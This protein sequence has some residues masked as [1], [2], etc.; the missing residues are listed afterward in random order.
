MRDTPR[1]RRRLGPPAAGI[2]AAV[3]VLAAAC[4]G[5]TGPRVASAG[6]ASTGRSSPGSSTSHS[7]LPFSHCMRSHGVPRYPD[8]EPQSPNFPAVVGSAHDVG[9][10]SSRLQAAE[11]AC[12]HTLPYNDS[13]LTHW[14]LAQCEYLGDCPRALVAKAMTELRSFAVCM[15]SHG[16]PRWPDP[17]VGSNGAPYFNLSGAGV[18]RPSRNPPAECEARVPD[19][20]GEPIG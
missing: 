3:A 10:S 15:R 9:V 1:R 20:G 12:Y 14:S 19:T 5:S 16:F 7:G 17:I 11:R 13:K 2:L 4:G 8:P 18:P 6:S